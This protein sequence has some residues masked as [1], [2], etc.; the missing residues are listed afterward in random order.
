MAPTLAGR[1]I[2]DADSHIMESID[3]LSSHADPGCARPA[4]QHA[5]RSHRRRLRGRGRRSPWRWRGSRTPVAT[6]EIAANVVT[7]PKGWAAYGAIDPV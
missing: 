2:N 5:A 1:V 6:A 3:W 4:R 7:G